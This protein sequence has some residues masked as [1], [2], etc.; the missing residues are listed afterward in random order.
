[1]LSFNRT[2]YGIEITSCHLRKILPILLIAP[3]MELKYSFQR[4]KI[5][6]IRSFNRTAYGI[7]I[8][9]LIS[10]RHPLKLLI[11]PLMELK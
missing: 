5:V 9:L 6:S 8:W 1:M 7:E 2:A 11:A 4:V 10:C 3:L